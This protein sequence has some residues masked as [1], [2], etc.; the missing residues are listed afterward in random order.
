M[1]IDIGIPQGSLANL[2][3]YFFYN[4]ELL[5]ITIEDDIYTI[6]WIDDMNYLVIGL[7]YKNNIRMIKA[8]IIRTNT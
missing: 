7:N 2:L 6:G 5:D 4:I 3:L 8:M 1:D